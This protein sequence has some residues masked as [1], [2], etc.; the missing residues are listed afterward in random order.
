MATINM[1]N[2]RT[3]KYIVQ[4]EELYITPKARGLI[5][6]LTA[7]EGLGLIEAVE[8]YGDDEQESYQTLES[9]IEYMNIAGGCV[10]HID[11]SDKKTKFID[12]NLLC[13]GRFIAILE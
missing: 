4:Y 5:Y 3:E 13:A 6:R 9:M 8:W 2:Y 10:V 1:Y 11:I 7:M 12:S